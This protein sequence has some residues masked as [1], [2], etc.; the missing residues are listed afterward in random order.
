MSTKPSDH[1]EDDANAVSGAEE[2]ARNAEPARFT[3]DEKAALAAKAS[4][5]EDG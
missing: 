1:P 2:A 5:N 4:C 3:D